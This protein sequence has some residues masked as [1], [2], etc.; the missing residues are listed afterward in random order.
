MTIGFNQVI[1]I[2]YD[3]YLPIFF[4]QI[5]IVNH[6]AGVAVAAADI[7]VNHKVADHL[8]HIDHGFNLLAA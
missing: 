4:I 2:I 5:I 3:G 7:F 1:G 6:G 8:F